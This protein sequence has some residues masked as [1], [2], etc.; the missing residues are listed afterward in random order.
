MPSAL[1]CSVNSPFDPAFHVYFLLFLVRLRATSH[2]TGVDEV[3]AALQNAKPSYQ[4]M[5]AFL[6]ALHQE[7]PAIAEEILT[8]TQGLDFSDSH[9]LDRFQTIFAAAHANHPEA[10][11]AFFQQHPE[12][13]PPDE[14][15]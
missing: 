2:S 3:G 15:T 5:V 10:L 4:R 8:Q 12:L 13:I 14:G 7:H 6:K 9:A 11:Q 1:V